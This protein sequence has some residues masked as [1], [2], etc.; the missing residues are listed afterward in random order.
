MFGVISLPAY[1]DKFSVADVEP[2]DKYPEVLY[3]TVAVTTPVADANDNVGVAN[4]IGV[5]PEPKVPKYI[6]P[7]RL[8]P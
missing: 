7:T 4:V 8:F 3:V 6:P 5:P 2:D 1:V